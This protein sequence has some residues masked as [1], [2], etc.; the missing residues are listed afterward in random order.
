[1]HSYSLGNVQ[2]IVAALMYMPK[3]RH[4]L[5]SEALQAEPEKKT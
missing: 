1:M 3:N 2:T 5:R 4:C